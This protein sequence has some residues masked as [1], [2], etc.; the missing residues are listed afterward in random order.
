M[1]Q[2]WV[3]ITDRLLIVLLLVL[4]GCATTRDCDPTVDP[5][6]FGG[7]NCH[8]SG[9]YQER[10]AERQRIVEEEKK[11][12]ESLTG[13]AR[14]TE[15]TVQKS[16]QALREAQSDLNNMERQLDEM[17]ST[18]KSSRTTNKQ[19]KAELSRT[20]EKIAQLKR[21]VRNGNTMTA[22]RDRLRAE[23]EK[24]KEEI[25]MLTGGGGM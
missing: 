18:L 6:L 1:Y 24:A 2:R 5:G 16:E 25:Q 17:E 11:R 7:I 8:A 12:N 19:L 22:E 4:S 13:E 23:L 10:I 9:A 20:K 14:K 21:T 15:Q 3:K